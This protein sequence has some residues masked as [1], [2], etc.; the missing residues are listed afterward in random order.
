MKISI[1]GELLHIPQAAQR[2]GLRPST[3]RAWVMR[4]KIG[5]CRIG[6]AVRIPEAEVDRILNEGYVPAREAR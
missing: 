1:K 3:L 4:Q 2:L 5:H 6:R